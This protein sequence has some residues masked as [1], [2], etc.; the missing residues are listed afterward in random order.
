MSLWRDGRKKE[1]AWERGGSRGLDFAFPELI[2]VAVQRPT[3]LVVRPHR[4][5]MWEKLLNPDFVYYHLILYRA[6]FIG[7]LNPILKT[8]I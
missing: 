5:Y 1:K 3:G 4:P 7:K 8:I 6:F 2:D